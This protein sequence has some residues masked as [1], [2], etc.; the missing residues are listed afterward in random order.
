V[1]TL[2]ASRGIG[3]RIARAALTPAALL[4]AVGMRTRRW[5]YQVGLRPSCGLSLPAVAVGGLTV[6]GAGKTPMATWIAR[7]YQRRGVRPA[8]LLRGYGG[9]EAEIHR[10][11][12]PEAVVVTGA[13]R[14]R[15]AR[16]AAAGGAQ[17]VVLDDA[18]QH[19]RVRP[20]VRVVLVSAESLAAPRWLLPAGPW[21]ESWGTLIHADLIVLTVRVAAAAAVQDALR[22]LRARAPG[23]PVAVARLAITGLHGLR[24]ARATSLAELA[25]KRV[26]A[27]C[28]IADPISFA[29][30]LRAAGAEVTLRAWRDHHPFN[31]RDTDRLLGTARRCDYVVVTAKDATKLSALWPAEAAEPLVAELAVGWEHGRA[32]VDRALSS[33]LGDL[34]RRVRSRAGARPTGALT[35]AAER[36][37]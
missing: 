1:T 19:L 8:V 26:L 36:E 34:P 29:T 31:G 25:G 14:V 2:W 10:A 37:R 21:R 20:D 13:D 4:Y 15:S 16:R 24:S 28:G 17:V 3:A 22:V 7:W 27:A 32:E 30:Q 23:R 18:F 6:G 12:V 11:A 9:D 5:A 33:C 35:A